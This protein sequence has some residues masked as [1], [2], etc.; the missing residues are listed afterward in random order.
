RHPTIFTPRGLACTRPGFAGGGM[1]V[2]RD[3][4]PSLGVGR[5]RSFLLQARLGVGPVGSKILAKILELWPCDAVTDATPNRDAASG[6]R[7][8]SHKASRRRRA[9]IARRTPFRVET[10]A[11]HRRHVVQTCAELR[12]FPA[13]SR[14]DR[15]RRRGV[16]RGDSRA[17]A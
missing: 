4:A 9:P 16:R 7:T 8:P 13:V 6:G 15:Q 3:L 2:R 5:A 11:A 12:L 14:P 10:P 1:A 17:G